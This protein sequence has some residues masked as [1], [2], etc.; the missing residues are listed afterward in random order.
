MLRTIVDRLPLG[1]SVMALLFAFGGLIFNLNTDQTKTF[2]VDASGT[3]IALDDEDSIV[4]PLDPETFSKTLAEIEEIKDDAQDAASAADF[5]LGFLEGGSILLGALVAIAVIA[6]GASIQ[7]V[8][9]RLD[10][11]VA[12]ADKRLDSSEN[13]MEDLVEKIQKQVQLSIDT[14]ERRLQASESRMEELTGRIEGSIRETEKTVLG[15]HEIVHN[16]VEGAKRDA[17]NSF[18][19]LSLLLLAEQ[20]VRA[21]NRLTAI[22]TLQEAFQID[23]TNQTTNYLLGYLY[24]GRKQFD[25]AI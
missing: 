19:V 25:T 4:V 24:V 3:Q 16:A 8:R 21:R 23:P 1:L 15:L 12:E 6:F 17:E 13:R 7:E 14:G 22:S 9:S 20:Q 11:T 2:I 10:E 18:R 5:V